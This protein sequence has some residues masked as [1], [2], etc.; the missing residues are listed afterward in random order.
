ML[1]SA[2]IEE[3]EDLVEQYGDC[4]VTVNSSDKP[5]EESPLVKPE[6]S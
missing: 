3:L 6:T 1:A 5:V 4:I 2:L